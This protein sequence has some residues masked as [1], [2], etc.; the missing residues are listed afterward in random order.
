MPTNFT[1]L[2]QNDNEGLRRVL[3]IFL[4]RGPSE[5]ETETSVFSPCPR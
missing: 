1:G 2:V 3:K 4:L 5:G